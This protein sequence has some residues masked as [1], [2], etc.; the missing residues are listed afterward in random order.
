MADRPD[1]RAIGRQSVALAGWETAMTCPISDNPGFL[2]S[3][4]LTGHEF[5]V[6]LAIRLPRF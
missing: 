6:L 2:A 5:Q 3:L 4:D 1:W